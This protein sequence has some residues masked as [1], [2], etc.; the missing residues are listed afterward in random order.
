MLGVQD[1]SAGHCYPESSGR[2]EE[3]GGSQVTSVECPY[4]ADW[5]TFTVREPGV[6]LSLRGLICWFCICVG[7]R[8][9]PAL[10]SGLEV[11]VL[12]SSPYHTIALIQA[13][14]HINRDLRPL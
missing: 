11:M 2:G 14:G 13:L 3:V 8:V 4:D 12:L 6:G 1:S 7:I 5:D 9:M 10:T